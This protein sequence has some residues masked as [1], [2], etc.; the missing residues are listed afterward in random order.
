MFS[1]PSVYADLLKKYIKIKILFLYLIYNCWC[2]SSETFR[3]SDSASPF[4]APLKRPCLSPRPKRECVCVCV[5]ACAC[6]C[7]CVCG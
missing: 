1:L 3:P 6:A 4:K 7:A 5:C 2:Q